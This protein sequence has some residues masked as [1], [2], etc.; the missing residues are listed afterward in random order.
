M[1]S[2]LQVKLHIFGDKIESDYTQSINEQL[3]IEIQEGSVI[4]HIQELT[5]PESMAL[6]SQCSMMV[7]T[8]GGLL[9]I[10]DTLNIPLITLATSSVYYKNKSARQARQI[11]L[12]IPVTCSPCFLENCNQ[13]V[14]CQEQMSASQVLEA[15]YAMM[16]DRLS[17]VYH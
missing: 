16:S 9:A 17:Q 7:S 11:L 1:T 12:N 14:S 6:I 4:N 10:A 2:N 13:S 3:S 15:V 8:L 5:L